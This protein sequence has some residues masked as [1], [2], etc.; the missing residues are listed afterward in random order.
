[1]NL[2]ALLLA[3]T[4][5]AAPVAGQPVRGY[6]QGVLIAGTEDDLLAFFHR[7]RLSGEPEFGAF[8]LE[9]AYEHALNVRRSDARPGFTLGS[10][11]GG[12]E[13]LDLEWTLAD[14]ERVVWR[15]RFDRLNIGWTSSERL[16]ITAG[17]QAVSWGTTLFLNPADPFTPFRPVDPFRSF[18]AGVDAARVRFSPGALSEVDLVVRPAPDG[19]RITAL[20]R[21]LTT[22]GTWEVS[23]WAGA[24]HGD[25]AAAGA[26]AGELGSWAVRSESVLR[27]LEDRLVFRGVVGVDRVF[28]FLGR[29][30]SLLAEYQRDGLGA[31]GPEGYLE[32]LVSDPFRRGEHQVL[33]R[34][35]GILQASLSLHPLLTASGLFLLNLNDGSGVIGP[36]LG[37]SAA[38]EIEIAA[39]AF[40]GFGADEVT[41]SRPLPSEYGLARLTGYLSLSWYF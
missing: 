13:W 36:G 17:R 10:S 33:G 2:R 3:L 30:L 27:S 15:H 11:P 25:P 23:G 38:D 4:L 19:D 34:D 6:L 39:G 28:R 18:R 21:G 12:G 32:V 41:S 37:Y 8:R 1:M 26:F 24:L 7:L 22:V 31:A 20:V 40:F 9:V 35:E 29:D 16:E 5:I 14:R